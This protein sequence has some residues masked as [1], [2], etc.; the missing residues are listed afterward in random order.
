[1]SVKAKRLINYHAE[2]M[3]DFLQTCVG[4]E[5]KIFPEVSLARICEQVN[6]LVIVSWLEELNLTS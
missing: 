2:A 4:T 5:Y 3:L 6:N 1:M